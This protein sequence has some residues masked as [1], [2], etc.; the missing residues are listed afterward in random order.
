[1]QGGHRGGED[2]GSAAERIGLPVVLKISSPDIPHKT[3]VGGVAVSIRSAAEARER[4]IE[5]SARA[6]QMAPQARIEGVVVAFR[7]TIE[8]KLAE[9]RLHR[10][11]FSR[12]EGRLQKERQAR[13][14]VP[15]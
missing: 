8:V 6:R 14:K 7:D 15:A 5:I 12:M 2:V 4:A 3:E 11:E 1:M 13:S 10:I 9:R